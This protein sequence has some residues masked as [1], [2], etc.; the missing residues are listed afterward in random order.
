[1]QNAAAQSGFLMSYLP[2]VLVVAIFYLLVLRPQSRQAKEHREMTGNLR[3]GDQVVTNGGIYGRVSK[4][5]D[6][7][8]LLLEIADGV[9]IK[10]ARTSVENLVGK[11]EPAA[12][13]K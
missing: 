11:G 10:V 5:I 1:M 4:V 6:D 13:S 12:D 7:Q 9:K 2:L 3:R 8:S